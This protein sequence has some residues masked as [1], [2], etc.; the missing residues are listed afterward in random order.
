ML[1]PIFKMS[2]TT[3]HPR[4]TLVGAGPGDPELITLKG[5]RTL[6]T[7]DVVLYDALISDE[8][9]RFAPAG[10]RKVFVGKRA[11][12]HA[13]TQEQINDLIVDFAF[14]YGHV[15]RLKGG[16]PFVFGRGYEEVYHADSYNIETAVIPG[17]SSSIAVPEL[18]KIPLTSRGVSESFWVI[19]GTNRKGELSADISRAAN[20]D[21][22]VIILMGTKKLREIVDVYRA[23]GKRDWPVAVIQNGSLPDQ[24]VAIG[25][26][27]TI[28][29]VVSEQKVGNPAVIVIGEVVAEH[30]GFHKIR[31]F[32]NYI[33][34]L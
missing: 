16:D 20:S 4:L 31:E 2:R 33:H 17:I 18:V 21:A 1:K 29:E 3:N 26:I 22:T 19:T 12:H 24:K 28:Q 27:E 34:N 30:P 6:A 25:I 11:G 23:A 7:A 10:A 13:Y 32:Y 14:R 8:L 9:L 5:I 15:V